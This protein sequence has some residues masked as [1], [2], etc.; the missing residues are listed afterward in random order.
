MKSRLLHQL[1]TYKELMINENDERIL[2]EMIIDF[3]NTLI[4]N[5]KDIDLNYYILETFYN[6]E[7]KSDLFDRLD[8]LENILLEEGG[9]SIPNIKK[10]FMSKHDKIIERDKKWLSAN[11]KKI[12]GMNYEGVEIE[13][14]SDYKVT[15]EQL[16]NRHNIFDKLFVNSKDSENIGENLRRFEDKNENLKN[17][18]DNYFRT[19]TSRREVGLRKLSGEDAKVAIENMVVYCESFLS[20]KKYI[21]EKMNN[22]IVALSDES[23]K[24]SLSPINKLKLLLEGD[25]SDITKV[26]KE[27][28]QASKNNSPKNTKDKDDKNVDK[29]E[30]SE[31]DV[32]KASKE[33]EQSNKNK[34]AK[35]EEN[36]EEDISQASE[37]LDDI[38]GSEEGDIDENV[39]EEITE[40]E[41]GE[42]ENTE[43]ED[44]QPTTER[45]INDRQIGVAVLLTVAEER[46]FDYIKLLKGLIEE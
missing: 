37:E 7:S 43:G 9:L 35:N 12:L 15:F 42:E 21:E 10:A 16:L 26:S 1:N 24:E 27:L 2:I 3:K 20:G 5:S 30:S 13:V 22:I 34:A 38:D 25:L 11:K 46:Y 6:I 39:D 33:I 18:L 36:T 29:E 4:K 23:V 14:L 19:G 31:K 41:L 45:G 28:S 44:T 17:G 8:K 40:D 32:L